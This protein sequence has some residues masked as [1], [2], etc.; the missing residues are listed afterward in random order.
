VLVAAD[1]ALRESLA[2]LS[3]PLLVKQCTRLEVQAPTTVT[4]ASA[5]T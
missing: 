2:G 4:V 5:A 1:P 3:A